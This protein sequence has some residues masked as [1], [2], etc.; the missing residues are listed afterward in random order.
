[1][2]TPAGLRPAAARDAVRAWPAGVAVLTTADHDG[3]WWACAVA[4]VTPVSTLLT[5]PPTVSVGIPREARGR[6]VL[7]SADAFAVHVL[8]AGGQA[9]ADRFA[10]DP[11]D[12]DGVAVECGLGSVP[13][14]CDVVARVECRAVEVTAVGDTL[15]VLGEVLRARTGPGEPLA[16]LE[17]P[18]GGHYGALAR[19][20]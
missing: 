8:R 4:S 17:Q 6:Q 20:A 1:M 15:L 11:A 14:L 16:H 5:R 12:F 3:W 9:L 2:I 19:P 13:L 7:T 18:A 10:H